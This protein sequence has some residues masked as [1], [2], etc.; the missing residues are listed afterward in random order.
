MAV[1][2]TAALG[3]VLVAGQ[4]ISAGN[5]IL[6]NKR[7]KKLEKENK[8]KSVEVAALEFTALTSFG[9]Y[10]ADKHVMKKKLKELQTNSDLKIQELETKLELLH[11][12]V[13][14]MN[15]DTVMMQNDVINANVEHLAEA[16][17]IVIDSDEKK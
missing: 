2:D 6:T 12:R 14:H 1:I 17:D 11:Q 16:V 15:I 10:M 5:H 7:L 8:W 4:A 9:C 13:D 3:A